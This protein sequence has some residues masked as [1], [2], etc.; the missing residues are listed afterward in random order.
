VCAVFQVSF[1]ATAIPA[2][3]VAS[4][5]VVL[6]ITSAV[7]SPFCY[8]TGRFALAKVFRRVSRILAGAGTT[9]Q[10][11]LRRAKVIF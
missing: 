3:P 8:V 2:V 11:I 1:G 5:H 9:F 6:V 10:D 7:S 4:A